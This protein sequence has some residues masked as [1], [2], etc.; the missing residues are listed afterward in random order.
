M[1]TGGDAGAG[2][3]EADAVVDKWNALPG[4]NM[5]PLIIGLIVVAIGISFG[6]MN[7]YAIRPTKNGFLRT[8]W[9]TFDFRD[10]LKVRRSSTAATGGG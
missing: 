2:G 7:G 6:G 9:R 4:S 3:D 10:R 8:K 5:A 1:G